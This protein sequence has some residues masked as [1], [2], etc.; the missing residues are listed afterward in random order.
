[1]IA[2]K[3]LEDEED[4]DMLIHERI[5]VMLRIKPGESSFPPEVK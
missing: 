2:E 5:R 4:D 1:M 3:I